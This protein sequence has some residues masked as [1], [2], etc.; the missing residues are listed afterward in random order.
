MRLKK[1]RAIK[2]IGEVVPLFEA[3]KEDKEGEPR[4]CLEDQKLEREP[5]ELDVQR[6]NPQRGVADNRHRQRRISLLHFRAS[7]PGHGQVEGDGDGKD[8]DDVDPGDPG[9]APG[10]GVVR[11]L[12]T[13]EGPVQGD[14]PLH[15]RRQ[16]EVVAAG[17]G[18]VEGG[19]GVGEQAGVHLEGVPRVRAVERQ[20]QHRSGEAEEREGGHAQVVGREAL[21]Q[22]G[23]RGCAQHAVAMADI[24]MHTV[25]EKN[26]RL[27]RGTLC[28]FFGLT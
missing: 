5:V 20:V 24:G 8:A 6:V 26:R 22:Q 15:R 4:S 7:L 9:R 10:A 23:Q 21:Q 17:D 13:S 12:A 28:H 2:R 18:H 25:E 3:E 16:V 27:V 14:V 11:G 1:N 19:E